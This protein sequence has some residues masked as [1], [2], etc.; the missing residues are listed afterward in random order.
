MK[1]RHC[2]TSESA[3]KWHIQRAHKLTSV[4]PPQLVPWPD[5]TRLVETLLLKGAVIVVGAEVSN[6]CAATSQTYDQIQAVENLANYSV[7][8]QS[9]IQIALVYIYHLAYLVFQG[10]QLIVNS[11][12]I[13]PAKFSN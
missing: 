9:K 3:T 8:E 13:M 10:H 1:H 4:V 12:S 2:T 5:W 7:T 11:R 6:F